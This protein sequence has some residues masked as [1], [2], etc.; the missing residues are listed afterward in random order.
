ME[1]SAAY[2]GIDWADPLPSEPVAE[3]VELLT[4]GEGRAAAGQNFTFKCPGIDL[5]VVVG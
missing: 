1:H 5:P 2:V 4:Y 3:A